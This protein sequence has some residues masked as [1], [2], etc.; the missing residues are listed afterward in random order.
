LDAPVDQTTALL[1]QLTYSEMGLVGLRGTPTKYEVASFNGCRNKG[2]TPNFLDAAVARTPANF[3]RKSCFLV[4][5]SPNQ[6]E[7]EVGIAK[8]LQK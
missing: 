7:F 1:G 4:S 3:G 2:G 5:Y 6:T 8:W